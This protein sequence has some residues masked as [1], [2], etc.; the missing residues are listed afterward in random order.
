VNS[1]GERRL[2]RAR[3]HRASVLAPKGHLRGF[4]AAGVI[5]ETAES[6]S[7]RSRGSDRLTAKAI[8]FRDGL[9]DCR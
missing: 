5:R 7:S 3:L 8:D 2:Y 1:L 4:P 6:A 9:I